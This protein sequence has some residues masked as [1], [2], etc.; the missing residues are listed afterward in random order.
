MLVPVPDVRLSATQ[1]ESDDAVHWQ[2]F[3]FVVIVNRC[4]LLVAPTFCV[5]GAS[6]YVHAG[7]GAGASCRTV[8]VRPSTVIVP[9][10]DG[11]L[12]VWNV[13]LTSPG[14]VPD[15]RASAI[16][17]TSTL[18]VHRHPSDVE[19]VNSVAPLGAPTTR[20]DGATL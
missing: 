15:V 6:E 18:A 13:Y 1:V 4:E 19:T 14:P 7:G 17:F 20:D 16:Q 11:P 12:L 8:S 3:R 10:R 9:V 5:L 2:S